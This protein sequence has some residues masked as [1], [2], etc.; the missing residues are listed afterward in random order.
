MFV[1]WFCLLDHDI[2]VAC[3]SN[4]Y[5]PAGGPSSPANV[6]TA[7]AVDANIVVPHPL[8]KIQI[9]KSNSRVKMFDIRIHLSTAESW[10]S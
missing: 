1:S 2:W 5:P 9:I 3:G 7:A 10:N 8:T 6:S 4:L